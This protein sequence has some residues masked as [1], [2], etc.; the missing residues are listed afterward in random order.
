MTSVQE[1]QSKIAQET[2]QIGSVSH[3]TV[4]EHISRERRDREAG[5]ASIHNNLQDIDRKFKDSLKQVASSHEENHERLSGS[6]ST[7][8]RQLREDLRKHKDEHGIGLA[9]IHGDLKKVAN[10]HAARHGDLQDL[11][12]KVQLEERRAREDHQDGLVNA[13]TMLETNLRREVEAGHERHQENIRGHLAGEREMREKAHA[14]MAARIADFEVFVKDRHSKDKAHMAIADR[15]EELENLMQEQLVRGKIQ[16]SLSDRLGQLE[17]VT[18]ERILREKSLAGLADRLS[19]M[20]QFI[21]ERQARDNA[22]ERL[23][24]RLAD[25]EQATQKTQSILANKLT[26]L[27][28]KIVDE[29]SRASARSNGDIN[30]NAEMQQMVVTCSSEVAGMQAMLAKEQDFRALQIDNFNKLIMQER[31]VRETQMESWRAYLTSEKEIRDSKDHGLVTRDELDSVTSAMWAEIRAHT[32]DVTAC[33]PCNVAETGPRQRSPPPRPSSRTTVVSDSR[34]CSPMAPCRSMV[35]PKRVAVSET[36]VSPK[37]SPKRSI[38]QTVAVPMQNIQPT[39]TVTQPQQTDLSQTSA[40]QQAMPRIE[41]TPPMPYETVMVSPA[42]TSNPRS[43][44]E[45]AAMSTMSSSR[46]KSYVMEK[47][48]SPGMSVRSVQE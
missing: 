11:I 1:L 14:A 37:V 15:V 35:S 23:V 16:A 40:A 38:G 18:Q 25:M 10:E 7:V 33:L 46:Y 48:S 27:D 26:E 29:L 43:V 31:A 44:R 42:S 45:V 19:G 24:D 21:Q 39:Q 22:Q 5:H 13:L 3:E 41:R 32:H 28:D 8:E 30:I 20:E 34:S 17:Q 12:G 36:I 47:S 9:S 4:Q 6:L 2:T